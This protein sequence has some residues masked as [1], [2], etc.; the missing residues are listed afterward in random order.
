MVLKLNPITGDLDLVGSGGG[1]AGLTDLTGDVGTAVS[2]DGSDNIDLIGDATQ[3]YIETTGTPASNKMEI[4]LTKPAIDGQLLIGH[5]ANGSP[6]VAT[7][8]AGSGI[9]ITNGAGTITVAST[10]TSSLSAPTDSGTAVAVAGVMSFVGGTGADTAGSG[11]TVTINA[12]SDVPTSFAGDSGTVTPVGNSVTLQGGTGITTVGAGAVMD[13]S[14]LTAPGWNGSIVETASVSASSDGA[15]ITFSVEKS[16]GGDLTVIFSDGEYA[17]D[18]TPAATISLTEGSDTSPTLN[19]VY[20]LK[21]TKSLTVS[22]VGWPNAEHAPLATVLCETAATYQTDGAYKFHVWTDHLKKTTGQGHIADLNFWIRQQNATYVSGV[23]QTYTITPNVGSAD[24][25]ILT[26]SA[27]IALQLHEQS[28][29]A[30]AGTPDLYVVND[31]A[32]P[33][34][35]VTDLNA[36]LT[37]STGASM[38][39]RYF[40]LVIWGVVSEAESDCKLMVT[41]PSGSYNNL[42]GIES[43]SSRFANYTI[44]ADFIGTGFL[45]SEWKLRHQAAGGGTWTSI[46]EI[47]IR[48]L[49]PAQIAGGGTA[50]S[51]EFA[52]NT[53]RIFD[54]GDSTKEIS[55]Q[56]SGIT[57]GNVREITMPDQDIDLTPTT[58]DFQG[59]D[60]TLTSLAAYNTNGIITQ[61]AADTFTGRTISG[62]A[63]IS[64]VNGDGVS[65]NPTI[66]ITDPIPVVNGGT[67]RASH[68][69]YAV[70]C[71]GTTTTSPQQ[72]ISSVGTTGQILTSNG[73]GALPTFQAV[74][75]GTSGWDLLDT[76][77]ASASTFI[78]FES[79]ID[80]TYNSYVFMF[81]DIIPT[82]D[83]VSLRMRTSTDGGSSYDEG[84]S[85]YGFTWVVMKDQTFGTI[86]SGYDTDTE[87]RIIGNGG[88]DQT[89]L[90]NATDEKSNGQLFLYNPSGTSY[91]RITTQ[92]QGTD[93]AGKVFQQSGSG[94]RLSAGNVDAVRFFMSSGTIASGSIRMY[95]I[96]NS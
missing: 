52:D 69:E 30:F 31:S 41:L 80:S 60:A 92:F 1:S 62:T 13:F 46:D 45:I 48:S 40:S 24:N 2:P 51:V 33:F 66:S 65:G 68:T 27:G 49:L 3:A 57:T 25:V 14:S 93:T 6:S 81:I 78:D 70:I 42:T 17:W 47:D 20:L 63:P 58:G 94:A 11:N 29:P 37:D 91:T 22:I 8:T 95:G 7:L 61:T 15:T 87:I 36:I 32:T 72:S 50:G 84:A 64:I 12:S 88:G 19:Y 34:T 86:T 4:K 54:D 21:S 10:A 44:P 73:A 55:F 28:F 83:N 43:D 75:T 71:G 85:D 76:Q 90:G 53:F 96:A 39:G 9:D 67:E 74:V 38:S 5:T 23:A 89:T 77:T 56:A 59:S 26:T 16:G 79:S 18:T 35:K 82:T